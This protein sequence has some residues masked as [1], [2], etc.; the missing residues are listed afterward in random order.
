MHTLFTLLL[1]VHIGPGVG[2]EYR[3]PQ[4]AAS[5][6]MVAATFGAG[7]NIY[8]SASHDQGRSF[9][10]PVKVTDATLG[11]LGRHRGPRVALTPAGIVISAVT[12]DGD[13]RSWRS[14]DSGKTWLPGGRINDVTNSA[15]EGLHAMS[16]G[17]SG[18]IFAAWLDLRA[19]GT[20]L[21]GAVS[22]DGGASW[23][24]NVQVYA[25]PI[26]ECCHPTVFI[27]DKDIIHAMWRNFLDGARDL[28]VASSADNFKSPQKLGFGTWMLKACPMD[29][30]GLTEEKGGKVVSI[31]RRESDIYIA[32]LGGRE[33]KIEPGKDPAIT[34]GPDGVYAIWTSASSVHALTPRSAQPIALADGAFP[35]LIAVPNGPVLA[36]W[37]HQGRIVIQP[38]PA[39][40]LARASG[41]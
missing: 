26:C 12:S 7:S 1:A 3:Q 21:Y 19:K 14:I 6:Q 33:S 13:L 38:L 22:K 29:G 18:V 41:K 16:A 20:R 24:K 4:L 25:G 27:D 2:V 40:E 28:Y 35:Q 9:S 32:A 34:A 36:A 8:F 37:E 30:G 39:N 15:R 23:S 10:T 5:R 31:W 17:S 11:S